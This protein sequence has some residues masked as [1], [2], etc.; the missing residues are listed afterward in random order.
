[1]SIGIV[2]SEPVF[3]DNVGPGDVPDEFKKEDA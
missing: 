3:G 2:P 1:M